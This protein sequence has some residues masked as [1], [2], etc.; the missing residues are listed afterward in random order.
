MVTIDY[1]INL[2]RLALE[3]TLTLTLPLLGLA[4]ALGLIV[5]IFQAAT[6]I[7]EQTLSFVPKLFVV[8]VALLVLGP[9]MLATL[10][11]FFRYIF[12]EMINITR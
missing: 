2:M 1:V 7:N 9:W 5:G 12:A 8:F 10:M 4:L 3:T 6:S 11:E